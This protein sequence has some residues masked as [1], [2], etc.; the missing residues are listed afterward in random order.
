MSSNINQYKIE[1]AIGEIAGSMLGGE[2]IISCIY[3]PDATST[4]RLVAGESVK[5][6][7]PSTSEAAGNIYVDERASELETIFGTVVKSAKQKEFKPGEPVKI[8]VSGAIMRLKASGALNRGAAVTP[9]LATPG[10]VKAVST[11]THYGVTLDKIADTAI[12]RV[13]IQADAV[14]VGSA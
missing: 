2:N 4:N 8:A 3:N 10:S 5:L 7:N 9:V 14:A 13:W 11:K 1:A 12:G 6:T